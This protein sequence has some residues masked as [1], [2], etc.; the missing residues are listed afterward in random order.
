MNEEDEANQSFFRHINEK[1]FEDR[2]ERDRNININISP[3]FDKALEGELNF[4]DATARANI[5]YCNLG[6]YMKY[7]K[8]E[9]EHAFILK[10]IQKTRDLVKNRDSIDYK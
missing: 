9:F 10:K 6:N 7:V 5:N 2:L 3:T 1:D 8:E 4:L